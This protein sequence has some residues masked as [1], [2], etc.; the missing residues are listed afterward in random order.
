MGHIGQGY[1]GKLPVL[2]LL[3]ARFKGDRTGHTGGDR[4]FPRTGP[5]RPREGQGNDETRPG[6]VTGDRRGIFGPGVVQ[7]GRKA[8]KGHHGQQ[9]RYIQSYAEKLK[10]SPQAACL[11][12]M[13]ETEK[14][15]NLILKP[16]GA[17][18]HVEYAN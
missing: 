17:E 15:L 9:Y 14:V 16:K 5:R 7:D 18:S 2:R 3:Q 6:P 1:S 13:S 12:V 8:G 10:L 4:L 11:R